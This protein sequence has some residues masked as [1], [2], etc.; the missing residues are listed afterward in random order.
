VRKDNEQVHQMLSVYNDVLSQADTFGYGNRTFTVKEAADRSSARILSDTSL[1]PASRSRMLLSVGRIYF[2]LGMIA[3]AHDVLSRAVAVA[4]PG[5]A[6][7]ASAMLDLA[8][9]TYNQGKASGGARYGDESLG[10]RRYPSV[11][12]TEQPC[13]AQRSSRARSSCRSS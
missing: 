13:R 6:D 5:S 8:I 12:S 10:P 2:G 1:D 4:P 9:M 3:N 11:R 7:E